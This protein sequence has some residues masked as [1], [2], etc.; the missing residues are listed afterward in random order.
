MLAIER[1]AF[2]GC[3]NLEKGEVRS[4]LRGDAAQGT[5]D[6]G[7][8]E[9]CVAYANKLVWIGRIIDETSVRVFPDGHQPHTTD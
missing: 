2:V 5:M 3:L 8:I 1:D 4:R 7:R 9:L 6:G